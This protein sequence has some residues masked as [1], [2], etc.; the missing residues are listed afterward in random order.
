MGLTS[1][2]TNWNEATLVGEFEPAKRAERGELKKR[3]ANYSQNLIPM[4]QCRSDGIIR[5]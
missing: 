2:S 4:S 3:E 5:G 1:E